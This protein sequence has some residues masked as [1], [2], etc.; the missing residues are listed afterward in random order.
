MGK[1]LKES[2]KKH[3]YLDLAKEEKKNMFHEGDG[4]TSCS[5][6]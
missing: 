5:R 4:D 3:K 6:A 1:K 2:V